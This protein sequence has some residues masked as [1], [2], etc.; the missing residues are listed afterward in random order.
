MPR[1]LFSPVLLRHEHAVEEEKD[2]FYDRLQSAIDHTPSNDVLLVNGDLNAR[3]G[4]VNT[5]RET[6]LGK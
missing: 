2:V 3:T 1:W 6:V 4:S 5:D